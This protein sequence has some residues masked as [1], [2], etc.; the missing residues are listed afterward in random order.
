MRWNSSIG[1][2][3]VLYGGRKNGMKGIVLESPLFVI[4]SKIPYKENLWEGQHAL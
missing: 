4:G 1:R 2:S 3:V